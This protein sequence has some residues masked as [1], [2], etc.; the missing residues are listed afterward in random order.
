MNRHPRAARRDVNPTLV[1][2]LVL[3]GVLLFA[4]VF[5]AGVLAGTG[6]LGTG[7][8]QFGALVSLAVV[9][10]VKFARV[11]AGAR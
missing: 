11:R 3:L 10:V 8:S 6:T 9:P 4:A 2:R 5:A 7:A 1:L